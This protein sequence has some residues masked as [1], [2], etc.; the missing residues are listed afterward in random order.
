MTKRTVYKHTI[1]LTILSEDLIPPGTSLET[2]AYNISRGPDLG[3]VVC[4]NVEEITGRDTI[5]AEC[6]ALN[7]D[8]GF[9]TEIWDEDDV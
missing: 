9:F 2:M 3:L 5:Q 8:G 4:K 6:K 7:N 1:K